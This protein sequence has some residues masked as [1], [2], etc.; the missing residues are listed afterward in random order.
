MDHTKILA[1][2]GPAVASSDK[3]TKAIKAGANGFRVNCSHGTTEDFEQAVRII[4]K[5]TGSTPYPISILFDISGP[6]LRL[7]RFDGQ[8]RI[9]SGALLTLTVGHTELAKSIVGVNHPG[10]ISSLSRKER[11]FI[12]DGAIEFEVVSTSSG[13]AVIRACNDGIIL[14]GKGIN[15]PDSNI[16]IP[17]IGPKDRRDIATAVR[18]DA[19]YIALSFVRSAKDIAVARSVVKRYRGDQQIIA[20]LEKKEAI[21]HLDEILEAADGVMIARGDLGVELPSREL[22]QLQKK[23]I[24]EA[25]RLG[26]L[27]IVATQMLES[28]RFAPRPTRAEVNDVASAV[29][30][31]VDV[32]MLS[33][34]TASGNYPIESVA[35]M[36]AVIGATERGGLQRR[37]EMALA[38]K[39]GHDANTIAR[40]VSR[41]SDREDVKVIF[42]FT[43]SGSTAHLISDVCPPQPVVALTANTRAMR[44]L[45]LLRSVYPIQVKHA[46]TFEG[47]LKIVNDVCRAHKLAR[48]GDK[49][50]ITGGA[51]FGST[52]PTNFLMIHKVT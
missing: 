33:A 19:D 2:Y 42:A 39:T 47:M 18:M 52:V 23:I 28:M 48:R 15:L 16:K 36:A 7:D 14:P 25:N 20:K 37:R 43:T 6:K 49:V 44:K 38:I 40:L 10:I 27:V 30:D 41:A 22:P 4:R 5:G 46:G 31:Y 24:R 45:T 35:T 12:D 50:I 3:I 1:T 17:T 29:F 8:I 32:V 9:R 11:L 34:E 13:K 21:G 51:P 26:K